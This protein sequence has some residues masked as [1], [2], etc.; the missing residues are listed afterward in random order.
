MKGTSAIWKA[1]GLPPKNLNQNGSIH[2][3][4]LFTA[5]FGCEIEIIQGVKS[6]EPP[7]W[8]LPISSFSTPCCRGAHSW[9][10]TK[11]RF[12]R[13]SFGSTAEPPGRGPKRRLE[14]CVRGRGPGSARIRK[15]SLWT[16][17]SYGDYEHLEMDYTYIYIYVHTHIYIYICTHTYIHTH[18]YIYIH[19]C[20][21]NIEM[22]RNPSLHIY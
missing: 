11:R 16:S 8:N 12:A 21:C 2:P 9:P 5:H 14:M 13:R 20:V 7:S 3:I 10:R 22:G 19:V 15:K 17:I 18:T 6:L 1:L 4:S